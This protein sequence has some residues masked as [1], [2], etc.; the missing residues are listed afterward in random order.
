[1]ATTN[2]EY[3]VSLIRLAI[4]EDVSLERVTLSVCVPNEELY[5]QK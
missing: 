3:V 2:K 1:M 4:P 5:I